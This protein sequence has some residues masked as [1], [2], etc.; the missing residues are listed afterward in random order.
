MEDCAM[1][2][3]MT[4]YL[5]TIQSEIHSLCK[6]LYNNSEESYKEE[7]SSNYIVNL[8]QDHDFKVT[9]NYMNIPN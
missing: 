4:S 1:K 5:S 3:E 8:L 7:K 6:Y 9:T 2:Q